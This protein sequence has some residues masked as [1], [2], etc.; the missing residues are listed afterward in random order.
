MKQLLKVIMTRKKSEI[1]R[2]LTAA[3]VDKKSNDLASDT[4]LAMTPEEISELGYRD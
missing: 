1:N 4:A 2:L 3:A